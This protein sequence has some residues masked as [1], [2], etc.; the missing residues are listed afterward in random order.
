MKQIFFKDLEI[1]F[2]LVEA[3]HKSWW[4]VKELNKE[5][6][7][8]VLLRKYGVGV[9]EKLTQ[10]KFDTGGYSLMEGFTKFLKNNNQSNKLKNL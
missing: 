4:I 6:N 3:K 5:N 9:E 1:G 8:V 2:I 7:T 10:E